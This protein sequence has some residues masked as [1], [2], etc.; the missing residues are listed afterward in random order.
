M[1][2]QNDGYKRSMKIQITKHPDNGSPD[3]IIIEDGQLAFTHSGI[4]YI[5]YAGNDDGFRRLTH[6]EAD[7]GE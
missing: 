7:D 2:Y 6:T 4:T 1:A 5:S 3:T